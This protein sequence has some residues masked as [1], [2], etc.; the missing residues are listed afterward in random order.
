MNLSE[1][2]KSED[3]RKYLENFITENRK[4]KFDDV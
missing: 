4:Q 3:Y 1:L 2:Y